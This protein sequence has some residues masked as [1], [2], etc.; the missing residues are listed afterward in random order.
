MGYRGGPQGSMKQPRSAIHPYAVLTAVATFILLIAGGLVTSTDSGLAVPD[1]PL[2]YG[3]W[4]PP[5]V[6]GI[7]YEHGHRMIA[8]CVGLLILTL[9]VWLWRVEPRRWVRRLGY[10]ALAA[11][12][13]Q[14]LLGGL[15]V[16]LLL[17]PQV[18]IAHACLGQTVFCLVVCLAQ[19]TASS[20][21]DHPA[22][23]ADHH[24]PSVRSL[25]LSAALL[26]GVQLFL[27]AVLRHTGR[28]LPLHL[29]GAALLLLTTGWVMIRLHRA[30]ETPSGLVEASRRLGALV[31]VQLGLGMTALGHGHIGVVTA[32]VAVGALILAQSVVL[33]WQVWRG[34]NPKPSA[35]RP[36]VASQQAIS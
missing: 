32:H 16:L 3:T 7:L 10:A 27:G 30:S 12:I 25:S 13:L 22:R 14:G 23:V 33:A 6:G 36:T 17:P 35:A 5:M 34:T 8:A 19:A 20:W 28:G 15:T 21:V 18:S 11:V 31:V 26:A 29:L 24:W 1:W 9:A 2:S 4:F